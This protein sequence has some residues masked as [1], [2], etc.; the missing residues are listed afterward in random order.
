MRCCSDLTCPGAGTM[1]RRDLS[2]E[3]VLCQLESKRRH[4]SV[5]ICGK[6]AVIAYEF[7][8]ECSGGRHVEAEWATHDGH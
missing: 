2:L 1:F 6:M 5:R 4:G 8:A 7:V 3:E